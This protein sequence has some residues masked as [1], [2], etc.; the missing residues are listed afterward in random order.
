MMID[1]QDINKINDFL[2][3]DV[4]PYCISCKPEVL[5]EEKKD[6]KISADK[7]LNKRIVAFLEE[8]FNY[9]ILS[10]ESENNLVFGK[11]NDPIWIID[12]LDGSLNYSRSIPIYCISIALWENYTPI[13]GIIFDIERNELYYTYDNCTKAF[14]N[15][16]EISTSNTKSKEKGI[17]CT[18][19]PS[20]R[21][22]DRDSLLNFV[23]KVQYWKKVRLLGSAAVS[24]A[25]VSAGRTDAYLEEDIRIW[26][27]AA[28]MA[29]VK[30]AGGRINLVKRD[31]ENFVTAYAWNG[32]T[33]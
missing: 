2:R 31:R 7:E 13:V 27:V 32:N 12:P 21:E 17:I 1:N 6:I 5:S 9:P 24:L 23:K 3:S 22:Y 19:F 33:Y 16:K 15:G 11:C 26:D 10:E 25:W 30:A 20:W 18:G 8:N 28:G 29:L 4:Y 14:L